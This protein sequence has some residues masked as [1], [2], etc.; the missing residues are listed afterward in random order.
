MRGERAFVAAGLLA[1]LVGACAP[2][3][4]GA[5]QAAARPA[6]L[7]RKEVHAIAMRDGVRLH[8]EVY[9]PTGDDGPW[10]ILLNRTPYGLGHDDDGFHTHL[11]GP[12]AELAADGYVFA[13]QDIRG[14]YGSEGEF[15]MLRPPRDPADP[16]AVDEGTD[17]WDTLDWLI[18]N[19]DGNNGRA[20]LLGISYGGWLTVMGMLE[21]HPALAAASPQASPADMFVGDDFLHNG[22]FRLAPSFGYVAMMETGNEN[23]P[24]PFDQRDVYEWYLELGPLANVDRLHFDG[25]KPT[26]TAFMENPTYT[27]YW[28]RQAVL[29]Y[30][31]EPRV[32]T[33]HVAGW[34]DAEDFYGPMKIY[35]RLEGRDE[36]DQS[37]LVVGP[38]RHGGWARGD[39]AALGEIPFGTP[40]AETFRDEMQSDFFAHYLKSDATAPWTDAEAIIFETGANRWQRYDSWPPAGVETRSLYLVSEDRLAFEPPPDRDGADAFLSDPDKPVPYMPRPIPGFWQGGQ[41]LWKVTDQRFVDGRPD[42]LTYRTGP[43]ESDLALAGSAVAKLFASTT[44]SDADW[45]VKLIDV[46]PEDHDAP[47]LRGF[48]LMIADE[49]LRAR[50]RNGFETAE[51]VPP[52]QVVEYTIDL[53]ERHHRFLAGHEIMVQIQSTWFPLIDRNPQTF[54]EP[55]QATEEDYRAATHRVYRSRRFPTRLEL[56]VVPPAG[57]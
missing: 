10:P 18:A 30:L 39:G 55:A 20:G 26:W 31:E 3:P 50:F 11:S 8:T 6:E 51:P 45:V 1:L 56:Q 21:P 42:V 35:H 36:G 48:Q 5:G 25:E 28:Q 52:G 4:P 40:T 44:G 12:Y 22:A 19:V 27:D 54:V 46:Y 47:E 34:W 24:F 37:F 49:V 9:V 32:P 14:R 29:P 7:F 17:T 57:D 53:G 41:A 13:F 38:W 33:L 15:V 16:H 23:A 43:L 2:P